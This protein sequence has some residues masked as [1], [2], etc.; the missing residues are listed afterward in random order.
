MLGLPVH[1]VC[2]AQVAVLARPGE[3]VRA[4]R[5][6]SESLGPCAPRGWGALA[7][8]RPGALRV[9]DTCFRFPEEDGASPRC[10]L[11][12]TSCARGLLRGTDELL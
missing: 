9:K 5:V 6:P 12:R 7:W 2:A 11:P 4:S 10:P 3:G 1:L 8:P